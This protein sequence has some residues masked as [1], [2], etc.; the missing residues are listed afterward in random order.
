M[1]T[2]LVTNMLPP[3]R[4]AFYEELANRLDLVVVVDTL[5][6]FNRQ[7]KLPSRDYSFD[8]K[9]ANSRSLVYK[10]S[11]P[12]VIYTGQRQ[13]HFSEKTFSI[14]REMRPDVI[15]TAEF[16]LRTLWCLLYGLLHKVPVVI[17]SEGTLH[18]EGHVGFVKRTIRR[19]LTAWPTRAWSNGPASTELLLSYGMNRSKI[20]EGMTGI[21][22]EEFSAA[23]VAARE[24]RDELRSRLGLKG[25]VFLYSGTF[26]ELKGIDR[27]LSTAA[28]AMA[29]NAHPPFSLLLL[30]D[31]NLMGK[32]KSW[33]EQHPEVPVALPG[34][35]Q[36]SDL[37]RYFAAAD[38][39]VIP[40]LDDNWPLAT[41]ECLV[42]GLPQL[43]S[44]YNGATDDLCCEDTGLR[45]DPLDSENFLDVFEKARNSSLDRIPNEVIGR[46]SERFSARAQAERGLQSLSRAVSSQE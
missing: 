22:T 18:T 23:V 29:R 11:R 6:E 15:V 7:W 4:L 38:W 41:L 8:I 16:G 40:T 35:I 17:A 3:Y 24:G 20:D 19:F 5:S 30:G 34:F 13:F 45:F 32:V 46:F 44:V 37:P 43:F 33:A 10:R 14:L 1:K 28:A 21:D 2:A 26:T 39:A 9:V 27:L 12:D 42:A 25:R 36:H 31:G